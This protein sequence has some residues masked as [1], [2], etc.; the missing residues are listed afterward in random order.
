[1]ITKE[2]I[3]LGRK[4]G[5]HKFQSDFCEMF[6]RLQGEIS[7]D[8]DGRFDEAFDNLWFTYQLTHKR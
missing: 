2:E 5:S 4:Y 8:T 7:F 1:M 6:G 3:I